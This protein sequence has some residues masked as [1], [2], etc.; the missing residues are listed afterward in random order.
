[1]SFYLA[2]HFSFIGWYRSCCVLSIWGADYVFHW[3]WIMFR[4]VSNIT[5]DCICFRRKIYLTKFFTIQNDKTF[6]SLFLD[7]T[8]KTSF[9]K[10]T[11]REIEERSTTEFA[12]TTGQ[13]IGIWKQLN[14][15]FIY[16]K[17]LNSKLSFLLTTILS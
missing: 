5:T 14:K 4:L 10:T 6:I 9:N 8:E 3:I 12:L 15:N 17:N 7:N 2:F 13:E 1:M 16:R 11:V